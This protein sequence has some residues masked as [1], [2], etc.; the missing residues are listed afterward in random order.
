MRG[1]GQLWSMGTLSAVVAC[2]WRCRVGR[3]DFF[4]PPPG[5]AEILPC[6]YPVTIIIGCTVVTCPV[7]AFSSREVTHVAIAL[8]TTVYRM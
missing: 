1:G 2:D 8:A 7:V 6:E 3:D 5:L 4:Y